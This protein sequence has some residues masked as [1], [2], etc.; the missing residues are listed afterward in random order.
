MERD[1]DDVDTITWRELAAVAGRTL[2]LCLNRSYDSR[3][4][5]RLPLHILPIH[6][7]KLQTKY[8]YPKNRETLLLSGLAAAVDVVK[9][10]EF[11][12]ETR[13]PHEISRDLLHVREHRLSEDLKTDFPIND[14]I[15]LLER[16]RTDSNVHSPRR[17][18]RWHR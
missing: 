3:S 17:W 14:E 4:S 8:F 11:K 16:T 15:G 10:L 13:T 12:S 5:L 6:N 1:L 9:P 2:S 18:P 7:P